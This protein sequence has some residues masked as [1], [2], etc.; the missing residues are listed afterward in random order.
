MC[1]VALSFIGA[2][3]D[4]VMIHFPS[5]KMSFCF[6]NPRDPDAKLRSQKVGS[7]KDFEIR[8]ILEKE[9]PHN[10]QKLSTRSARSFAWSKEGKLWHK[11]LITLSLALPDQC[12][13]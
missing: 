3:S 13:A 1:S 9:L 12:L 8:G 6:N 7:L 11:Y 4:R 10:R 2:A 5:K